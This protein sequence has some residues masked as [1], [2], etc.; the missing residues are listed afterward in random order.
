[1]GKNI[2]AKEFYS[3]FDPE[4]GQDFT[5]QVGES[6]EV[7]DAKIE[8][9]ERDG[10]LDRFDVGKAGTKA[11]AAAGGEELG[12]LK[13]P[14]LQ[15]KA[16]ELGIDTKDAEGKDL[17]KADLIS[18]IEA[19]QVE[20]SDEL[21]ELDHEQLIKLAGETGIAD[22]GDLDAD[23]LRRAIRSARGGNG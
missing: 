8:Q 23:E 15:A 19:K 17:K 11:P 3:G 22:P 14:Q 1:M 5:L 16:S 12:K 20:T 9:L 18:A 4:T 6:I 2:T 7:S 21:D 10:L 13:V